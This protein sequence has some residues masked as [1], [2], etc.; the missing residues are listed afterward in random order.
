MWASSRF[1]A[2]FARKFLVDVLY[3]IQHHRRSPF[4]PE[5]DQ[6][7]QLNGKIIKQRFFFSHCCPWDQTNFSPFPQLVYHYHRD[8]EI[9]SWKIFQ[10]NVSIDLSWIH[11]LYR[12]QTLVISHG[13]SGTNFLSTS[14]KKILTYIKHWYANVSCGNWV[15]I[16]RIQ[17]QRSV[18]CEQ[19]ALTKYVVDWIRRLHLFV[20]E[21]LVKRLINCFRSVCNLRWIAW[22][23]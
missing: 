23:L 22:T 9:S 5:D 14:R 7:I 18:K 19:R 4:D 1:L 15:K 8:A 12:I 11:T 17:I 2:T 10:Q 20:S 13:Q 21:V 3:T 16:N 6:I